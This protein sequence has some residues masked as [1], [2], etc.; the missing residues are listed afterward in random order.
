MK[1]GS[2][3]SPPEQKPAK[4]RRKATDSCST[5]SP[6]ISSPDYDEFDEDDNDYTLVLNCKSVFDI[7]C[8]EYVIVWLLIVVFN[9]LLF[10]LHRISS[11]CGS[12][13][14]S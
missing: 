2:T 11:R 7:N 1:R 8:F 13:C 14:I 12:S 10:Y 9:Y 4:R 3:S 5:M 6:L